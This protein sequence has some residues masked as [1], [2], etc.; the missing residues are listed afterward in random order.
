MNG[1]GGRGG[2]KGRPHLPALP[3]A[4]RRGGRRVR[5]RSRASDAAASAERGCGFA[6][7]HFSH[8]DVCLRGNAISLPCSIFR[9][10]QPACHL[11]GTG[12]TEGT[13]TERVPRLSE[14]K[15]PLV[16]S[17]YKWGN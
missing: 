12:E 2:R 3:D 10:R 16:P 4:S 14:R 1:T 6:V 8:A 11:T 17:F 13:F 15:G 7:C 9:G 5:G